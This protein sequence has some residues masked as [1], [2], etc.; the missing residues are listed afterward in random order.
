VFDAE[1]AEGAEE[2]EVGEFEVAAIFLTELRLLS[3]F[4]KSQAHDISIAKSARPN[5]M[6]R[7]GELLFGK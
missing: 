2:G 4:M 6:N 1:G 3:T 7:F 5:L